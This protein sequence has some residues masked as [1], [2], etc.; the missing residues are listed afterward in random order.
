[1]VKA[2][3]NDLR[4]G[5]KD[6][7]SGILTTLED[8]MEMCGAIAT[9]AALSEYIRSQYSGLRVRVPDGVVE[10]MDEDGSGPPPLP[11][12]VR[13]SSLEID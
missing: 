7:G 6:L 9:I 11:S 12:P 3:Y 8:A 1:M 2:A 13:S 10:P 4:D 5:G